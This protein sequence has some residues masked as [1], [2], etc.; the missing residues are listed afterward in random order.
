MR[1]WYVAAWKAQNGNIIPMGAKTVILEH[2]EQDV[3]KLRGDQ[4]PDEP[5][6]FVAYRDEPEWQPLHAHADL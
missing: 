2:V 6:I 4:S 1:R 3:A 5:P